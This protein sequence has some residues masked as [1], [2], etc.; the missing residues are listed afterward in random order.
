MSTKENIM[1]AFL[2]SPPEYKYNWYAQAHGICEDISRETGIPIVSVV[3]VMAAL[4]PLKSWDENIRITKSFIKTGNGYHVRNCEEKARMCLS[5]C[6]ESKI[7][8]L[9]KGR[10][11]SRFFDNILHPEKSDYVTID[12]HALSVALGRITNDADYRKLTA[13]KYT[14]IEKAYKEVAQELGVLPNV[15][16]SA[17]WLYVRNNKKLFK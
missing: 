1:A 15:V 13:K 11:I 10:K 8:L 3:G 9:L 14:E 12:R 16:Q 2:K 17:T 7:F 5:V 6:E 4:S